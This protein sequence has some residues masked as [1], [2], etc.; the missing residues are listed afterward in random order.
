[1]DSIKP[2]KMDRIVLGVIFTL[3]V[4]LVVAIIGPLIYMVVASFMEP[5]ALLNKGLS[6]DFS[7]YSLEGYRMILSDDKIIG[8]FL[9]ALLY[10]SVFTVITVSVCVFAGYPLS[11]DDFVGRKIIMTLFIITMFFGGGLIPTYLVVK[12]LGMLDTIWALVIPGA[13]SV[14]NIIL[15]RTFFRGL[16]KEMNEA[17][18]IDGASDF[19]IFFSIIIPLS[20]PIVFVLALYAF[21]GHWNDFFQSLIYLE[22]Q[23]KYPLQL[24]LRRIL[25]LNKVDPN[26]VSSIKEQAELARLSELM[27]YAA[28]VV[29]SLPL[30]VMYPFFQKYF[31]KGVMVGSLK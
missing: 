20:K 15:A 28:I 21:V 13:V 1:M 7:D 2:T 17:A 30:L 18:K 6:F 11:L 12:S 31:E 10:S 8:G 24:V 19:T 26:I 9:N 3:L 5:T 14:W 25:I 23:D 22:N 4:L 27:K 16:P 29:S